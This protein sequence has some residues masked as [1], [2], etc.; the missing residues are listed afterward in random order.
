MVAEA[1]EAT[2]QIFPN[3]TNGILNVI[4]TGSVTHIQI[5]NTLGQIVQTTNIL[6]PTT[7]INISSLSNGIY[8][9]QVFNAGKL[10]GTSKIIKE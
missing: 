4:S 9:L 6:N 5:T 2:L 10:L 1:I 7:Q 8:F 3:P